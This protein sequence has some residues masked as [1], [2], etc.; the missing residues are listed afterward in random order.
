MERRCINSCKILDTVPKTYE[1]SDGTVVY[2]E[3]AQKLNDKQ[4][5]VLTKPKQTRTLKSKVEVAP[6]TAEMELHQEQEEI[7]DIPIW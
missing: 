7:Q 1:L 6:P 3:H 5:D 2:G 4:V